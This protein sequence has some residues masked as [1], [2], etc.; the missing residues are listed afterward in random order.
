MLLAII[1][2]DYPSSEVNNELFCIMCLLYA[3]GYRVGLKIN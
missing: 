3:S 1:F 2:E